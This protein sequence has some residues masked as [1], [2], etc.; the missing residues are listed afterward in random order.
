MFFNKQN[1]QGNGTAQYENLKR[2]VSQAG[3]TVLNKLG[4]ASKAR[5]HI[6][7]SVQNLG[8]IAKNLDRLVSNSIQSANKAEG[9]VREISGSFGSLSTHMEQMTDGFKR[10]KT[11]KESSL[12]EY[13]LVAKVHTPELVKNTTAA[14][15]EI[16][17]LNELSRQV[18][19]II[20]GIK[21]IADQTNLLALNASIEAARAGE[22]GKGFAVVANE[23]R[24]LAEDT[25]N[26]LVQMEEFTGNIRSATASSSESVKKTMENL[27]EIENHLKPLGASFEESYAILT[28]LD[29]TIDK[30][31]RQ[32]SQVAS[33]AH[34]VENSVSEI[35]RDIQEISTHVD[36]LNRE[37]D[38]VNKQVGTLINIGSTAEKEMQDIINLSR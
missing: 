29:T 24:Q 13:N 33:I 28:E 2:A 31:G 32:M 36:S 12:K 20:G 14:S 27:K 37:A 4:D 38:S 17:T 9:Y 3:N 30:A 23:I 22:Q 5:L 18:D 16:T 1:N 10:V 11:I 15:A 25:K 7:S 35:P 34:S 21:G 8:D 26:K 6:A 19:E